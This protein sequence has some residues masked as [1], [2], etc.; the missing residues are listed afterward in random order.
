ME[1]LPL[2]VQL[3]LRAPYPPETVDLDG[4]IEELQELAEGMDAGAGAAEATPA[5]PPAAEAAAVRDQF[6]SVL[7]PEER[8]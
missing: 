2:P 8:K 7:Q 6:C 3:V 1:F 4:I 5:T